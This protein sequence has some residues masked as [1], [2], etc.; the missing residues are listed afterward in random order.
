[1]RNDSRNAILKQ[2]KSTRASGQ[3]KATGDF[4]RA[5]LLASNTR[6]AE[7]RKY[8][9]RK[10]LEDL[11]AV[12]RSCHSHGEAVSFI[13]EILQENAIKRCVAWKHPLLDRME[14]SVIFKQKKVKYRDSFSGR[15]DFRQYCAQADLG[16]TAAD[17]IIEESGTIVVRARRGWERATSLLPPVHLVVFEAH[18]VVPSVRQLPHLLRSF[19]DENEKL[20]SA[21]HLITGP[22]RTADIEFNLVLGVHGPK[23]VYVLA[24]NGFVGEFIRSRPSMPLFLG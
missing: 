13:D 24:A 2:L 15:A 9:L 11:S 3:N 16:I 10:T 6:T 19:H 20:P 21:V 17:A 7:R 12:M 8:D 22:S 1:M 4:H 23:K 14:L 5:S 18:Q